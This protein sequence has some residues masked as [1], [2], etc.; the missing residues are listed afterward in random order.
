LEVVTEICPEENTAL[1]GLYRSSGNY[2]TQC[3]PEGFR[4][5]TYYL[6][7]PDVMATYTVRIAANKTAC[8]ILLSNGNRIEQGELEDGR[9]YAVWQDPFPKPCYLFALVAGRLVHIHDTFTTASGRKVDLYIYVDPGNEGRC[10]HAM[11]SLKHAMQWDEA[12]YGREYD[13]D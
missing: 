3:E 6:D 4:K 9:H 1:E 2:C 8:P 12:K 10:A 13:L 11:Q 7:R 5:I